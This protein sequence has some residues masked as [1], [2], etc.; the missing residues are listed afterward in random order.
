[1]QLKTPGGIERFI[2]TIANLLSMKY[3][4]EIVAN[5]GKPSEKLAFP[6]LDS[7][8]LSFL[9]DTKPSEISMKNLIFTFKWLQIPSELKRRHLINR[10][11]T[12]VF[13]NYLSKL[14]TDCIITD[15]E[16]YN[17]LV[18]KYYNG[19][20][21]KIATDHNFHQYNQAYISK[22]LSSIKKFDYLVLATKALKDYYTPRTTTKCVQIPN[23]LPFISTQKS[24]L[25]NHNLISI[26]RLVP[27]KDFITLIDVFSKVSKVIPDAHLTIIGD[28]PEKQKIKE[29]ISEKGINKNQITLTGT[30]SQAEIANYLLDSSLY[31][32][33]STTEAFGLVLTESM[34]YGVPCIALSRAS[35]AK[36]QLSN[37][38]GILVDSP[39]EM[40]K[41][42]INV[43]SNPSILKN[44]QNRINKKISDYSPDSILKD[45]ERIIR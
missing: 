6:L 13:K 19:K 28:G 8:K 16:I 5:Y 4:V 29:A 22:L 1:M 26:G 10:T 40:T 12:R 11:R 15:R 31:V 3:Q 45:W 38:I 37:N 42:I 36:A 27:E 41:A 33:T 32:M 17:S 18:S 43:L 2:S 35:G 34:N 7:I 23:P 9:T 14:R 20:S 30:L 21:T 44:Y 39:T 25:S 24:T